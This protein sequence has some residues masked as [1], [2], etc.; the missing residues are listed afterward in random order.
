MGAVGKHAVER[1]ARDTAITPCLRRMKMRP[2]GL[3]EFLEALQAAVIPAAVASPAAEPAAFAN[4]GGGVIY[5]GYA[6]RDGFWVK[7]KPDALHSRH[8]PADRRNEV[9]HARKYF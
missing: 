1:P 4:S 8:T 6:A 9:K 3:V 5:L 7:R 2:G